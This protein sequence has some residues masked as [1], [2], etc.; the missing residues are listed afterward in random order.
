MILGQFTLFSNH[1][2]SVINFAYLSF[3][4]QKLN[5]QIYYKYLIERKRKHTETHTNPAAMV[6]IYIL[7]ESSWKRNSIL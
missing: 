4:S 5:S 3:I 6:F 7:R 1:T 2:E